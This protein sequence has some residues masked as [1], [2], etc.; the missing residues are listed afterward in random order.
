MQA[1]APSTNFPH[2]H[3]TAVITRRE[4]SLTTGAAA[5][6]RRLQVAYT[7]ASSNTAMKVESHFLF[8]FFS[9]SCFRSQGERG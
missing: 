8:S 4:V 2:L 3:L 7:Q 1:A 5:T 9:N 6:L